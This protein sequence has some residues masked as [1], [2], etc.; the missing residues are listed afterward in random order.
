MYRGLLKGTARVWK[1]GDIHEEALLTKV[2]SVMQTAE[3]E[4]EKLKAAQEQLGENEAKATLRELGIEAVDKIQSLDQL[5]RL[6]EVMEQ[7]LVPP[8]R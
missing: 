6:V 1:P 8:D 4:L 2:W 7:R 3:K 5:R